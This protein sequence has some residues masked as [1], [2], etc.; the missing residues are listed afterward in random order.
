MLGPTC[1][2]LLTCFPTAVQ[3]V[4]SSV[5]LHCGRM[6]ETRLQTRTL[7]HVAEGEPVM[8]MAFRCLLCGFRRGQGVAVGAA[9]PAPF[10]QGMEG[11][12][13]MVQKSCTW[14]AGSSWTDRLW[15]TGAAASC[16]TPSGARRC[17]D[18][19]NTAAQ[20]CW[21]RIS[22]HGCREAR[23]GVCLM[24]ESGLMPASRV[25]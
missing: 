22:M 15:R 7:P 19:V 8:V 23:A 20:F 12:A 18:T 4:M 9:V 6:G 16:G 14:T 21:Q 11:A 24:C 1:S 5:C 10:L 25:P 13:G 2:L 3:M 17:V